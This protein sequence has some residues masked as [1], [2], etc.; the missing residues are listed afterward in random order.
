M[1]QPVTLQVVPPVMVLFAKYPK[2]S[3]YDLSSVKRIMCAA[4]PLS[5]EI[6]SAVMKRL[7]LGDIQQGTYN[8]LT[9][10]TLSKDSKKREMYSIIRWYAENKNQP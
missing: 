4:A 3:A 6:E 8:L 10:S 7:N 2:V 5:E 1:F 9:L